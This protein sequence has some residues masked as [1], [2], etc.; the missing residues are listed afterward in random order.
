MQRKIKVAEINEVLST[1]RPFDSIIDVRSPSEFAEDHLP[2]SITLPVLTD[3]ERSE[4]GT[5]YKQVDPFVARKRG[6]VLTSLNIAKHLEVFIEKSKDW[7]PLVYCWRGGQRS[8]SMALVMHEI[9]WPVTLLRGGYKAYRKKIQ[10]D[11]NQMILDTEF[12][13]ITGPTGCGKTDLLAEIGRRGQQV[14]DLEALACHRG[15]IL[16]AEP[17]Q[18]QP[19]QKLFETRLYNALTNID[20]TKPVFI[21]SESSKIGDIHLPKQLFQSLLDARAIGLDCERSKRAQYSVERYSHLTVAPENTESLVKQLEFRHGTRQINEWL[22]LITERQW[23][24]L[25]ESLLEHHYDPAYKH[26]QK[27]FQVEKLLELDSPG[28][29][30][31]DAAL[32]VFLSKRG[33]P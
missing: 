23:I 3:L 33:D 21:E 16:G 29:I 10:N 6:A 31:N 2:G 15:S 18:S 32:G 13:V 22:R 7:R 5:L 27:R 26:S 25:A 24:E 30:A 8:T 20:Q 17:K 14:L 19:S 12:I 28:L 4:V 11:L 9:G 1:D